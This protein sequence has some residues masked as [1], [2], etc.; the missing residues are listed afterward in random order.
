MFSDFS[1]FLPGLAAGATALKKDTAD[2][3]DLPQKNYSWR[4]SSLIFFSE[5]FIGCPKI[6]NLPALK[7]FGIHSGKH[8]QS[9]IGNGHRNNEFS[10]KKKGDFH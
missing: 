6:Q 8:S 2:T 7:N 9:A 3:S 10:H 4:E 1:S 5:S